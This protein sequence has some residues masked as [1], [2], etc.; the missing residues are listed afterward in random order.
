[1]VSDTRNEVAAKVVSKKGLDKDQIGWIR[2]EIAIHKRLRHPYICTLHGSF[3]SLSNIMICLSLCR[4]G[5]LVDMMGAALDAGKL[6]AAAHVHGAFVKLLSALRY[7]ESVSIVHRDI[8]LDNLVWADAQRTRLQL[9]DFGYASTTDVHSQYSGSA[10]FAAPEVH[11][12]DEGGPPF[13]CR[14]ADVWSAGVVLFARL[15]KALPFNGEEE[16]PEERAAL[17]RK[18]CKAVPDGSLPA[19]RPATACDLVARMLIVEPAERATLA[20][21]LAHEWV[22]SP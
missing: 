4:G 7:L 15:A 10:H 18:V 13:L 1:L 3:K 5:S 8:K 20:Q 19:E 16:M 11:S 17:R 14:A 9:I 12:A 21:V 2:E 22:G 6:L